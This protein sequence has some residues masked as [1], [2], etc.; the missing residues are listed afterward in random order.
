MTRSVDRRVAVA[1]ALLLV[2]VAMAGSLVLSPVAI[3]Q[4]D[5]IRIVSSLATSDFPNN[6]TFRLTA[7]SPDPIE[8]VRVFLKPVGSE[9][10][11]Y[12]YLDI[13]PGR[14]VRGEYIMPTGNGPNHRPPGTVIRYSYEIRDKAGRVLRTEEEEF[15]YLDNS[16]EWKKISEGL[17]TVYYHGD[18][19]EKRATTVLRATQQT[20]ENM[21]R[22]LGVK[23]K[24]P[25][26][27]VSY[28]NYRDLAR[29]LPFRSQ[30]VREELRTE[31]TA[32]P[33]ERVL[34]LLSSGPDVTGVASH[35][36][37]HI[38][39]AEAAG[40]G[41]GR[42]PAWLNEGLAEYANLDQ[43]PFY[44]RA[45]AYAVYTRRLKPLWYL[46]A[47]TGE[48]DDIIIAYGQGKS[49]VKH[50]IDT[51]GEEKIS[52]L[53]NAFGK[54]LSADEALKEVY[55]FDQYGLDSEWRLSLGLEPLPPPEELRGELTPT[56][57]P[58][59]IAESEAIPIPETEITPEPVA[60]ATPVPL[61]KATP[62]PPAEVTAEPGQAAEA[63]RRT[64]RSC[65]GPSGESASPPLDI[66]ALALLG[67]P[68]LALSMGR[69]LGND[70]FGR[71]RRLI[72]LAKGAMNRLQR[73]RGR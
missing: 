36:F 72:L 35:E 26:N 51:Y 39:L 69:A 52:E 5:E 3:G 42:V 38:L 11:T 48:P 68:F 28:S 64:T 44:D 47:F 20:L 14:Q 16:L 59:P 29:A 4:E 17:L 40:R 66:A 10:S 53:M 60:E 73:S 27:I 21:G 31:G 8:E 23:P 6:V 43:T 12:G 71:T 2:V 37:T 58:T 65:D 50:L 63:R 70:R 25:I 67:G 45:L 24:D 57:R 61:V 32:W 15:L 30:S 9:R 13:E 18:F 55:G 33:S 41:Y 49:A 62:V 1:A 22:V 54:N 56:S 7:V 34:L 46:D 19:V